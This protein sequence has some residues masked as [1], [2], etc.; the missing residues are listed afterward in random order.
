MSNTIHTNTLFISNTTLYNK[1]IINDSIS[2]KSSIEYKE[3]ILYI[4]VQQE[5]E[6]LLSIIENFKQG[7]YEVQDD[8]KHIDKYLKAINDNYYKVL[9]L[10][11][12]INSGNAINA[13]T[14]M[15]N[16]KSNYSN[17][18]KKYE[19]KAQDEYN[20]YDIQREAEQ[21][22]K[23]ILKDF[24]IPI[25][26]FLAIDV[27]L[28]N[29]KILIS[30]AN[31][32]LGVSPHL[33]LATL[34]LGGILSLVDMYKAINNHDKRKELENIIYKHFARI[35]YILDS[36]NSSYKNSHIINMSNNKYGN[37]R[38]EN[39]DSSG[40]AI[41]LKLIIESYRIYNQFDSNECLFNI[42]ITY[43][44]RVNTQNLRDSNYSYSQISLFTGLQGAIY[45]E[46][47]INQSPLEYLSIKFQDSI[48]RQK[49]KVKYFNYKHTN[50]VLSTNFNN[51]KNLSISSSFQHLKNMFLES[52]NFLLAKTQSFSSML[53][54]DLLLQGFKMSSQKNKP[55]QKNMIFITTPLYT[56]S[57][58]YK[59]QKEIQDIYNKKTSIKNHILFLTPIYKINKTRFFSKMR[60]DLL[61]EAE[62]LD[63]KLPFLFTNRADKITNILNKLFIK[64]SA[65]RL[66]L[67]TAYNVFK[68]LF[69]IIVVN[70][71]MGL[72]WYHKRISPAKTLEYSDRVRPHITN[73]INTLNYFAVLFSYF[74]DIESIVP[75]DIKKDVDSIKNRFEDSIKDIKPS[76]LHNFLLQAINIYYSSKINIKDI[77]KFKNNIIKTYNSQKIHKKYTKI[78]IQ[79]YEDLSF[80]YSNSGF[81]DKAYI[82][83][84]IERTIPLAMQKILKEILDTDIYFKF[85]F[86]VFVDFDFDGIENVFVKSLLLY[87]VSKNIEN[88]IQNSNTF[89]FTQRIKEELQNNALN[90]TT[91]NIK[92]NAK[93]LLAN[94]LEHQNIKAIKYTLQESIEYYE[95]IFKDKKI[96]TNN[97]QSFGVNFLIDIALDSIFSKIFPNASKNLAK[98]KIVDIF[99]SSRRYKNMPYSKWENDSPHIYLPEPIEQTFLSA[100]FSAM[101][102][103]G[104]PFNAGCC[105]YNPSLA[106]FIQDI[107]DT[108]KYTLEI[109][110]NY[111]CGK[112]RNIIPL[113]NFHTQTY[114]IYKIAYCKVLCYIDMAKD[115]HI[116]YLADTI[117]NHNI[118]DIK[119]IFST[120]YLMD[121]KKLIKTKLKVEANDDKE[122][123]V[124]NNFKAS[125][126]ITTTRDFIIQLKRIAEYNYYVYNG[127]FDKIRAGSEGFKEE[128]K[129]LGN[130]VYDKNFIPT[131]IDIKKD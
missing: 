59:I 31:I 41:A 102:I 43:Q 12:N 95:K 114:S 25:A 40:N 73:M 47:Y 126:P 7:K 71:D 113:S 124:D 29:N 110:R 39:I 123:N 3:D 21:L 24:G 118:N 69:T 15:Q 20:L 121:F 91:S 63:S 23:T 122:E 11:K 100:D 70:D 107:D 78:I 14:Q 98:E 45:D 90:T 28:K 75:Q 79:T 64:N 89:V 46:T 68:E 88:K 72:A 17:E 74:Y 13:L 108:K 22:S 53:I 54:L 27:G 117:P 9:D 16:I 103:G 34:I 109:L 60:Q 87:N 44:T 19:K 18:I 115:E 52:S 58:E 120:Q 42:S 82:I 38:I 125:K 129:L 33:R 51:T 92:P 67:Q 112:N 61:K 111:I 84:F 2:N 101:L 35:L 116:L 55:L 65:D 106:G 80:T 81:L 96:T 97:L 5:L 83:N 32:I 1:A 8:N 30:L 127:D 4:N 128:P 76:S 66:D 104:S 94:L 85:C 36:I 57:I 86:I 50:N 6:N 93:D 37:F 99:L 105:M 49:D 10:L 130:L 48:N 119:R 26:I 131:T 77:E 62:E 56:K